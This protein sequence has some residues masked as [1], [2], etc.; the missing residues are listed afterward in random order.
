[1]NIPLTQENIKEIHT[2]LY[3]I[4]EESIVSSKYIVTID[5]NKLPD[6]LIDITNKK[7]RLVTLY[8][9]AILNE[10]YYESKKN[11]LELTFDYI[12][13]K[14]KLEKLEDKMTSDQKKAYAE[15][16]AAEIISEK[17]L[18]GENYLTKMIELND[19][20]LTASALVQE[21]KNLYNYLNDLTISI[22]MLLKSPE[23][24]KL[25]IDELNSQ[26]EV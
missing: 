20:L 3:E 18:N 8:N 10:S 12:L 26:L 13:N 16:R 9:I 5:K 11:K 21:I 15:N 23:T 22:G 4:K 17:I 25:S 7:G 2:E 14:T 24:S 6:I 19:N 1:M